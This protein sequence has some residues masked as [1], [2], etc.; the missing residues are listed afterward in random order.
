MNVPESWREV[1]RNEISQ[2]Y[3]ANLNE[4]VLQERR[5]FTVFPPEDEVFTAL[6]LTSPG[7]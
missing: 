2:P 1:L 3:F 5:A 4:I 7:E 6:Q